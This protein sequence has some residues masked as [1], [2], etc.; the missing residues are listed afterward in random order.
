MS[1]VQID[2]HPNPAAL[3]RFGAVVLAGMALVGSFLYF[4]S[5]YR[6][7]ALVVW[8]TGAVL[9]LAGLTG[10]VVAKPGYWLW[11]GIAFVLGSLLGRLLLALLY[12]LILTRSA[13]SGA[14]PATG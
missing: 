2:W 7:A 3:R 5:D 8:I 10:T 9:G 6:L 1:L 12:F 11:M 4:V 14:R 13:S